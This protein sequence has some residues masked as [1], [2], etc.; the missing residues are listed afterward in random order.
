MPLLRLRIRILTI[1]MG[2]GSCRGRAP[3]RCGGLIC[4]FPTAAGTLL[5]SLRDRQLA[6]AV[7]IYLL[8]KIRDL[9]G[10]A[11]WRPAVATAAATFEARRT[12]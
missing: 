4:Q 2:D 7:S 11:A 8:F 9:V 3:T 1:G 10:L 12:R 6:P 5:Y